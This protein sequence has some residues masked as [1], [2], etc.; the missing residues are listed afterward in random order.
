MSKVNREAHTIYD[1]EVIYQK[2]VYYM[3]SFEY[4]F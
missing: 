2:R 1:D 4:E 3:L